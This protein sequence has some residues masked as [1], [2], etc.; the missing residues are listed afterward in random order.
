MVKGL[1]LFHRCSKCN[2]CPGDDHQ[3]ANKIL[4]R[5]SKCKDD[6]AATS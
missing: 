3:N 2:I 5:A 4:M 6:P 1:I